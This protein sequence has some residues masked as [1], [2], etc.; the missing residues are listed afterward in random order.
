MGPNARRGRVE[1]PERRDPLRRGRRAHAHGRP[2][3]VREAAEVRALRQLREVAE[4][5]RRSTRS[6]S[7]RRTR[8]TSSR[9]CKRRSTSKHVFCEKPFALTR[10]GAERAVNAVKKA[11]VT[12]GLGYNRRWH[13]EMTKLRKQIDSG[14]LGVILH[15]EATMTFPNALSAQGRRLARGSRRDAVRRP[16]A[17][18]RARGRRDDRSLR[19][20]RSR[21][22]ARASAASSRSTRT[23]RRRS[24]SA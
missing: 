8:C 12:L 10:A 11:G 16:D 17:D 24:C 1:W 21:S 14:E 18:G 23:T 20:D 19:P 2:Q 4:R 13:P 6:C 15:V 22:T 9:S 3:G 5:I 7:R